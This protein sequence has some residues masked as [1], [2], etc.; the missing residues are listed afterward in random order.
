MDNV[1]TGKQQQRRRLGAGAVGL[2]IF[3]AACGWQP[4]GHI[5]DPPAA[6]A[7]A[8]ASAGGPI[9]LDSTIHY[10]GKGSFGGIAR[11]LLNR[12][13]GGVPGQ[14]IVVLD[15]T[16]PARRAPVDPIQSLSR[17]AGRY[18]FRHKHVFRQGLRGFS[19]AMDP[20]DAAALAKDP[21]V[22][23]VVEDAIVR[24]TLTETNPPWG[25]DRIGQRDL[26][27][28]GVYS[29]TPT[30]QGVNV[31]IVD[32]GILPN[33]V[34]FGGRATAD[35]DDVDDGRNGIDCHGHGTHVAGI[36][37]GQTSGVAK[38]ARIH[39]VRVLGCNG[40]GFISD[41][42][43]ALEWV[44]T[45]AVHPAVVNMS[46]GG[47]ASDE[48]D[49]VVRSVI[50]SGIPVVVA[51]GND[52]MY[53]EDT[54]PA[55][56]SEAITVGASDEQDNRS[57]FSNFGRVVDVFAPGSN[58]TSAWFTTTTATASLSGTSMAAPHV[59]GVAA[60]YLQG[61][62]TA[63]PAQ[64]E[65]AIVST[66]TRGHIK[67][68]GP[69]PA[70]RLVYSN[71]T[72]PSN[73]SALLVVGNTT[74]PPEDTALKARLGT[75]GFSV[76]IKSASALTSADASGKAVVVISPTADPTA[77]GSKL[78]TVATPVVSLQG[79]LFDDLKMTGTVQGTDFGNTG[80]T[81]SL[82]I[83]DDQQ[84][85]CA[86]LRGTLTTVGL[87]H[88]V[89][90]SSA[91]GRF[92]G[93]PGASA[94]GLD[95]RPVG[96]LGQ[97]RAA[98]FGYEANTAMVG[99]NAPAR[100]VG[101]FADGPA[102]QT[103]TFEGWAL[104][105][106]AIDW[107]SGPIVDNPQVPI[108]NAVPSPGKVDLSWYATGTNLTQE[109][110]RATRSGGP[111]STI[112][113]FTA[114]GAFDQEFQA[115]LYNYTDTT[116]ATGQTYYYE[117]LPFDGSGK[118]G[119]AS[120]EVKAAM[121]VPQAVS[122]AHIE[123]ELNID[124]SLL[125]INVIADADGAQA[126]R[127]SRAESSKGPFTQIA[128]MT[129][130]PGIGASYLDTN[131]VSDHVYYYQVQPFNAF[132][133]GPLTAPLEALRASAP[134]NPSLQNLR[135]TP[136]ANGFRA[137]WDHVMG[138][139]Q[140]EVDVTRQSDGQLVAQ[141]EVTDA[142]ATVVNLQRGTTYN[143]NVFPTG[144][145]GGFAMQGSATV[146][147]GGSTALLVIGPTEQNG[148]V[149]L[150]NEL[151][152]FGFDVTERHSADLVASD[153]TGKDL[154]LV[155]ASAKPAEVGTKLASVTTPVLTMQAYTLPGLLMTGATAGT[156][157]G[158][159]GNQTT[160]A[161]ISNHPLA[162][163]SP[164]TTLFSSIPGTFGWGIPGSAAVTAART[165][166]AVPVFGTSPATVFGYERGAALPGASG[167][168]A[169][170]RRTALLVDP[171]GLVAGSNDA[172]AILG[173]AIHWT[174]DPGGADPAVPTGLVAT[175]GST[176]VALSWKAV[177]GATSYIV[178]REN[179]AYRDTA[180]AVAF[181]DAIASVPGVTFNDTAVV[182][183][184]PYAYR[185]AA[186]GP[187]GS[188]VPSASQ[189]A[190]LSVVPTRP[191][192][193]AVALD[194]SARIDIQPVTGAT[195][196]RV[197][198]SASSGGPY[199]VAAASLAATTTSY[200][201]T[202][203]TNGV[204]AFFAVEAVNAAG[205]IRSLEAYAIPHAALAAPTGLTATAGLGQVTLAWSAVAN[206]RGYSVSRAAAGAASATDVVVATTT[207]AT[208]I[209][210]NVPNGK[211]L[212][213]FVTA[214]G[215]AE[216]KGPTSTVAATAQGKAL[217]VRAATPS[218]GDNVLRDKLIAAGFQVVEKA[219]TAVVTADATGND[220]VV[221]SETVTSGNVD[222]KFSMVTVPVLTTE[223]SILDDLKMTG[224]GLGTDFGTTPN[225]TQIN[226][227]D[228]THPLA[229]NLSGA[230]MTNTS[231]GT[232]LW[233]VPGPG[234]AIVG[235]L[236][237]NA[238]RAT[239]FGYQAGSEMVGVSAPARR[240]GL[241][242]DS[243]AAVSLTADGAALYDAAVRWAAGVR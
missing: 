90:P 84:A 189:Y 103:L 65:A 126:F 234:A 38:M 236:A 232:F 40:T 34:E 93:V 75:D 105:D 137:V 191:A 29:S 235:T 166:G 69:G 158:V 169:P 170:A 70:N 222:G 102:V 47:G 81:D 118:P 79:L 44:A 113:K 124:G 25:L 98:V 128:T 49:L 33:H 121:L 100:R 147:A 171:A 153:A 129:A 28:N 109:V 45:N 15:E 172:Q 67:D 206:A 94:V 123:Y 53:A 160:L 5:G 62:P 66:A 89:Q 204:P 139:S 59:A 178:L 7:S 6:S 4:V 190:G 76:T 192:I 220:L 174:F 136:I 130:N 151:E 238:A 152:S 2:A 237:S 58:I 215:D 225:Q 1:T 51:A 11:G 35:F 157:F 110:H 233:G 37:G 125:G 176:S 63:T 19:A 187:S 216:T 104:F 71:L 226:V 101:F 116:A 203:L 243:K 27:G 175:A 155:S 73:R 42:M 52:S 56:V 134:V 77:V 138:A 200:T 167:A 211:A 205:V 12:V 82:E 23:Y 219:D 199:T 140:Y 156:N 230:R 96:L 208:L 112:A 14:Y 10:R 241:F 20:L 161:V 146:T 80:T 201:V 154:V 36:V 97:S 46:L 181:A 148:D 163:G 177:P 111:Y 16:A 26:P 131:V 210:V 95:G 78:T 179:L 24:T 92:W 108:I 86:G 143:L 195:S 54:S 224:L 183:G 55:R 114:P 228:A 223:P 184:A 194:S 127:V 106:A 88:I 31:Y 61:N 185:V 149:A 74:L 120:A 162:A 119:R 197:L 32:T 30:G 117:V 60:L 99:A 83:H 193:A 242:I 132:G 202:G 188:S 240:V 22:A 68:P 9:S 214:L 21:E 142:D 13:D 196:L 212:T 218:A 180:R 85:L 209:D 164:R 182:S 207:A 57:I 64:V 43:A 231:V 72:T 48:E 227:V 8:T 173:A 115:A 159:F 165:P 87:D 91:G 144:S 17:L 168:T 229:A 50:Q 39:A 186:V 239:L 141:Q 18:S 135:V 213:Y 217:F 221:V 150:M 198:R 107:A 133:D 41:I 3:A 122:F 145:F